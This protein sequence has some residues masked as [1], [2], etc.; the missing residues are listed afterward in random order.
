MKE[1]IIIFEGVDKT[2]KTTLKDYFNKKTNFS[3]WVLD[4]TVISSLVYE[5]LFNRHNKSYYQSILMKLITTFDIVIIYCIANEN[6]IKERLINVNETLPQEL[7]NI[8][9][10]NTLFLKYLNY[11]KINYI[12]I[13]TTH[14]TINDCFNKIMEKL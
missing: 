3:Y 10:I 11:Y 9:Y 14:S 7:T 1:K 8:K 6:V 2:G 5:D 12:T 4:R 13:D